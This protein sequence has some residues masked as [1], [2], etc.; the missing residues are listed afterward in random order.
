MPECEDAREIDESMPEYHAADDGGE[1]E[2]RVPPEPFQKQS[3]AFRRELVEKALAMA[4]QGD[5][6]I[7]IIE[8]LL[9]HL[10]DSLHPADATWDWGWEELSDAA[11]EEVQAV[12][13][14]AVAFIMKQQRVK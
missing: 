1:F 7:E 4:N 2:A 13:K 3:R 8:A 9:A 12:R 11:Q 5:I 10:P 14:R 6:Q